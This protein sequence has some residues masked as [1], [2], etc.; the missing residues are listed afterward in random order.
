MLKFRIKNVFIQNYFIGICAAVWYLSSVVISGNQFSIHH[1]L[2]SLI[3]L[4]GTVFIYNVDRLFGD[5]WSTVRTI[6]SSENIK[7]IT[8][9]KT[10]AK[11]VFQLIFLVPF[12]VLSPWIEL[13]VLGRLVVPGIIALF[14]A[15]PIL[16]NG[17][18]MRELPLVKIFAIAFV[19]GWVG[20]FA[21]IDAPMDETV[22]LFVLRFLFIYA[23]TIPF[24]LRDRVADR[25]KNIRTVP[26]QIGNRLALVSAV[27]ALLIALVIDVFFNE[28]GHWP[29]LAGSVLALVLI[30]WWKRQRSWAYYLVG[31]DGTILISAG[32]CLLLEVLRH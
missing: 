4:S 32:L 9:N 24:D 26:S 5:D 13:E 20:A 15:M 12:L 2:L 7:K 1:Y 14:Y 27:V 6:F 22:W 11:V 23:I 17:V 10:H 8:F 21:N 29:M 3:V 25:D 30:L 28:N 18:R 16:P 19:W 31:L